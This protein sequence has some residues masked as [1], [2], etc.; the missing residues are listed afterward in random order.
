MFMSMLHAM[1]DTPQAELSTLALPVLDNR[2]PHH[3][4]SIATNASMTSTTGNVLSHDG[5]G[6]ILSYNLLTGDSPSNLAPNESIENTVTKAK[7]KLL[8]ARFLNLPEHSI[9][10]SD[11]FFGLGGDSMLALSMAAVARKDGIRLSVYDVFQNSSLRDLAAAVQRTRVQTNGVHEDSSDPNRHASPKVPRYAPFSL[12]KEQDISSLLDHAASKVLQCSAEHIQDIIPATYYQSLAIS[13]AMLRSQWMLNW[14]YLDW[15]GPIDK[16]RFINGVSRLVSA[17]ELLRTVFILHEGRYLQVVLRQCTP[18]VTYHE[19]D[20]DLEE[21]T[22]SVEQN[23]PG[24]RHQLGQLYLRFVV[25]KSEKTD[26]F[27]IFIRLSHAQYDGFY[28]PRVLSS[29]R[30]FYDGHEVLPVPSFPAYVSQCVAA[31]TSESYSYWTKL[32]AGASMTSI[33]QR[34]E[35]ARPRLLTHTVAQS[36]DCRNL[37]QKGITPAA[38]IK[39]AWG[40]TLAKITARSDILFGNIVSGRN[41]SSSGMETVAGPCLNMVPVRIIFEDKSTGLELLKHVQSQQVESMPYE[42]LGFREMV[43]RCADWPAWTTFSTTVQHQSLGAGLD[44]CTGDNVLKAGGVGS[45]VDFADL[46]VVSKMTDSHNVDIVISFPA[47]GEITPFFAESILDMLCGTVMRFGRSP[48]ALLP[49]AADL[50]GLSSQVLVAKAPLRGTSTQNGHAASEDEQLK[51][52]DLLSS[53]WRQALP[54]AKDVPETISS[55]TSFFALGGDVLDLGK[56]AALLHSEGS[57]IYLDD[58]ID[59]PRLWDQA[60]LLR[61]Q[62]NGASM[63]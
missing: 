47:D 26:V 61:K 2:E 46:S 32:L 12:V 39:A 3:V 11:N 49:S 36:I 42:S 43:D 28:L 21:F 55:D 31:A 44:A 48:D 23:R 25:V 9:D 45:E 41:S 7:L 57:D 50:T 1:I 4:P 38:I 35:P 62:A 56:V 37:I 53:V 33:V 15:R 52:L 10:D 34:E 60:R 16:S 8:W 19:T 5:G 58:L 14:F 40:L 6:V 30:S 54:K 13:G 27:R 22:K 29:L 59:T 20:Q 17:E 51:R 63:S 18:E 24:K